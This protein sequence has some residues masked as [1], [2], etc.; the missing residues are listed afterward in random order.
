[1]CQPLACFFHSFKSV[2]WRRDIFYSDE[3]PSNKS[4]FL[5]HGFVVLDKISLP[6]WGSQIVLPMFSSRSCII[7]DFIFEF[8]FYFLLILGIVSFSSIVCW[9]DCLFSIQLP[10]YYLENQLVIYVCGSISGLYSIDLRVCP[11]T[12]TILPWSLPCDKFWNH[13]V[14][15]LQPHFSFS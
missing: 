5:D 13:V 14:R 2:F 8:M 3:G 11:F 9:K 15:I 10:F 6:S 4:F 1:M 7:L 12:S